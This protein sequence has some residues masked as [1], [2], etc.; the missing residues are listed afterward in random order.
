[1]GII[2]RP[3]VHAIREVIFVDGLLGYE[4]IPMGLGMALAQNAGA[5]E[6]FASMTEQKR[7]AFIDGAKG[8]VSKQEMRAY[9]DNIISLS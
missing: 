1:M 9:V 6:K 7:Q 8:V 2:L 3:A 5:L 4:G